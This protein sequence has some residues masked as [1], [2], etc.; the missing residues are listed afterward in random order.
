[1]KQQIIVKG[2]MAG[3][4]NKGRIIG[5]IK[6]HT[7][8]KGLEKIKGNPL[9]TY[10]SDFEQVTYCFFG[11]YKN[12]KYIETIEAG[13]NDLDTYEGDLLL[14]MAQKDEYFETNF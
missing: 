13:N 1:M 11:V 2:F 3:K 7:N 6:I 8:Q 10:G 4:A 5:T 12:G 9:Q 14:K